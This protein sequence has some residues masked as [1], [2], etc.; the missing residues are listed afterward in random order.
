[1]IL[2]S[3]KIYRCIPFIS[4][5]VF[6]TLKVQG[7]ARIFV[8]LK[9]YTP[10]TV[11]EMDDVSDQIKEGYNVL[12]GQIRYICA[13]YAGDSLVEESGVVSSQEHIER[14]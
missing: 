7:T 1:M 8:S 2:E 5:P 4:S 13:V 6:P 9:E 14:K 12:N 3:N 10:E 11:A